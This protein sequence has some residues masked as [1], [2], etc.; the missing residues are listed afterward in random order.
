MPS[1]NSLF[2]PLFCTSLLLITNIYTSFCLAA[3]E[4]T[5]EVIAERT[6]KP[7]LFTQGLLVDGDHF[8]ETSGLY[9][10]SMLV[11]YPIAEPASTWAKISAPFTK[12][13]TIPAHY[14]A[15]GLALLKGKLY[16]LTW[17]EKSLLVYDKTTLT[18]E[19]TMS[20]N[21]EGWGLTTDGTYLIRSDGSA[22]IYFHNPTDFSVTNTLT[23]KEGEQEITQLNE[24]EFAGGFLW[25]NIWHDDRILKIDPHTGKVVAQLNLKSLKSRVKLENS[26]QVL[27]GIAWDPTR[28]AL[29]VT[30]KQ[31]PKMFLIKIH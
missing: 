12:K 3:D 14:F 31:W 23:V 5:F 26:E 4:L 6:H 22:I 10:Q 11:T 30:G 20:Y 15:E 28:N 19:K 24:L 17:M 7:V 2:R 1:T 29:W 21:G 25:A 8:Y 13:Q 16:V 18:Y 27:N 9:N